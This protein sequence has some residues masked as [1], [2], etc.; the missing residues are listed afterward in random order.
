VP[1][2]QFIETFCITA[3]EMLALGVYPVTHRLGGLQDT[4][5]DAEKKNQ[6]ILLEHDCVTKDE[7]MA[8]SSQVKV[9][10]A[11]RLWENVSLDI[12]N[13]SWESIAREWYRMFEL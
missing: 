4:L 1:S 13:H 7:I 3:L 6:A 10:L 9:V 11:K 12:N 8:Y 2:M 5:A